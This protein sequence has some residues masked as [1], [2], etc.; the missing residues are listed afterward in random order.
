MITIGSFYRAIASAV[1]RRRM[2]VIADRLAERNRVLAREQREARNEA[3]RLDQMMQHIA[4][5]QARN[6]G[7]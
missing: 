7:A 6:K 1:M 5:R 2:V 3:T 4:A